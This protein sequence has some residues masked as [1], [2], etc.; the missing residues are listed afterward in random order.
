MILELESMETFGGELY[1]PPETVPRIVYGS[2]VFWGGS[3]WPSQKAQLIFAYTLQSTWLRG[4]MNHVIV[5]VL[6][7]ELRL[8]GRGR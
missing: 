6:K 4:K 2:G 3:L 1:Y 7:A 8:V 5:F